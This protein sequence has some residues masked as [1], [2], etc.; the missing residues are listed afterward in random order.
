MALGEGQRLAGQ[1]A[2]RGQDERQPVPLLVTEHS[3]GVARVHEISFPQGDPPQ[4]DGE[5]GRGAGSFADQVLRELGA[6]YP[7]LVALLAE[8]YPGNAR[9][10]NTDDFLTVL[11]NTREVS[12]GLSHQSMASNL[13]AMLDNGLRIGVDQWTPFGR[14]RIEIRVQAALTTGEYLGRRTEQRGRF[15][16][17]R[18]DSLGAQRSSGRCCQ[19]GVEGA[20]S[21]RD[22]AQGTAGMPLQA[23]TAEAGVRYGRRTES[24]SGFALAGGDEVTSI[25]T[26]GADWYRYGVRFTVHSGGHWRP[27]QWLRGVPSGHLIGTQ[28]FVSAD[29]DRTLI[30]PGAPGGEQAAAG[31]GR[32]C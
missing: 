18:S 16:A 5:R 7:D 14:R 2:L 1:V 22:G 13:A 25:T 10:R 15:S 4:G 31:R 8:L 11:H 17:P 23:E 3:L 26:G 6:T 32:W 30:G 21:L 9:W 28:A 19:V 27:R 29:L 20:D 12:A 24:E